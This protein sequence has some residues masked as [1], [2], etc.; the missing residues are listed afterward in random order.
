ML[1]LMN[2]GSKPGNNQT[3]AMGI[4][5]G[6]PGT[7]TVFSAATIDWVPR[8]HERRRNPDRPDHPQR[9]RASERQLA[10]RPIRVPGIT[11]GTL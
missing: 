8:T 11:N 2:D 5:E 4:S 6:P 9:P 10:A 7:G 3:A 1:A